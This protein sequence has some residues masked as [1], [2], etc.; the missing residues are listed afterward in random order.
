LGNVPI[1][2]DF[3]RRLGYIFRMGLREKDRAQEVDS[4]PSKGTMP[5]SVFKPKKVQV[6]LEEVVLKY[7]PQ[8]SFRV[9]KSLG[10][11]NPD[12]ED[13][14]STIIMEVIDSVKAGKFRGESSIGTFIYTVTTRKIIDYIRLKM[15]ILPHLPETGHFPDPYE[16]LAKKEQAHSVT[17]SLH[18]LK[19]K[20]ADMLYLNFYLG[21]SNQEISQVFNISPS[22]VSIILSQAKKLLKDVILLEG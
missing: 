21:L 4:S 7:W 10:Y 13:V 16:S 5:L 12:W 11:A 20:Y 18:K 3:A 9:R 8:V 19:P 14:S 22:R 6:D 15:K 1:K 2:V 17:R